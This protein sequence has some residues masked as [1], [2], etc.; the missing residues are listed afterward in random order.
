MRKYGLRT[1]NRLWDDC[2]NAYT[3][4]PGKIPVRLWIRIWVMNPAGHKCTR[5]RYNG[6]WNFGALERARK[7]YNSLSEENR[8][9]EVKEYCPTTTLYKGSLTAGRFHTMRSAVFYGEDATNLLPLKNTPYNP[10]P[11]SS[12][13]SGKQ[14]FLVER[15]LPTNP[16]EWIILRNGLRR[17]FKIRQG[18]GYRAE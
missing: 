2:R 9:S 5:Y 4:F 3:P 15:D 10:A 11:T 12:V 1:I 13:R 8:G 17:N 18:G 6:K 14:W 16:T 7:I